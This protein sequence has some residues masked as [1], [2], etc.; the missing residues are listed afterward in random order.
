VNFMSNADAALLWLRVAAGGLMFV[1]HGAARLGFVYG[2]LVLKQPWPFV[3]VVER[4]GFPA[5]ALF[6]IASSLAESIA[7]ALLVLGF[8]TRWAAAVLAF[9]MAV[10]TWIGLPRGAGGM[11]L[12]GLYLAVYI[13]ILIAGPGQ[14]SL[15]ARG[16]RK[17]RT[18]WR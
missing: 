13:A 6:A 7:A 4:L 3:G 17:K 14:F 1:L 5:P 18:G 8:Q 12:P 10:A 9:N 15:D 2:Y 16:G 11:E